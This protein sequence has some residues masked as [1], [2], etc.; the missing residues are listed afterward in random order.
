MISLELERLVD[1]IVRERMPVA[2]KSAVETVMRERVHW[3][4]RMLSSLRANWPILSVVLLSGFAVAT[5]KEA[6]IG[7]H[8]NLL[9]FDET[10]VAMMRHQPAYS[11]GGTFF[12]RAASSGLER[13][14]QLPFV[15]LPGQEVS[16][17]FSVNQE[18]A[19]APLTLRVKL[20][21]NRGS[22]QITIGSIAEAQGTFKDLI[23]QLRTNN[24]DPSPDNIYTLVLEPIDSTPSPGEST[25]ATGTLVVQVYGAPALVTKAP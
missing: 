2:A 11:T 9:S 7:L 22:A 20:V 19:D 3:T 17:T 23:A 12:L 6:R 10:F 8:R 15:A 5:W 21:A 25:Y 24:V 16:V 13:S 4:K 14:F 1:A 18:V